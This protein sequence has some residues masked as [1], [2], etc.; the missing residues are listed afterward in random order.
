[1]KRNFLI[2]ISLCFIYSSFSSCK[3][4][5]GPY[6]S[7]RSKDAR[8]I[9]SWKYDLTLRNGLNVT[10]ALVAD[11]I[12]YINSSI[13]FDDNGKFSLIEEIDSVLIIYDG[14]WSFSD[15]K[16]SILIEYTDGTVLPREL[17]IRKLANKKLWLEE[18]I[19]DE[20]YQYE[21]SPNR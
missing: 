7:L 16:E 13:G 18:N 11:E 21:L 1:M 19:D 3:Y 17:F 9:N 6:I 4:E 20:I 8:V 2:V 12:N 14:T 15:K 5:E 10:T